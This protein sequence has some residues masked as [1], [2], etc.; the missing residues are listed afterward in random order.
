MRVG[1]SRA[2]RT[3]VM[4]SLGPAGSDAVRPAGVTRRTEASL[5]SPD[6]RALIVL[7]DGRCL[8]AQGNERESVLYVRAADTLEVERVHRDVPPPLAVH[9]SRP[10][11]GCGRGQSRGRHAV[12]EGLKKFAGRVDRG[13]RRSTWR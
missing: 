4:H 12:F 10:L 9:P 1:Y 13:R 8:D 7:A 2:V 6:G 5:P 3:I 11:A